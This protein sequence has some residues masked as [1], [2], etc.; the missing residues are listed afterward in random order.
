M[1]SKPY[2]LR[3]PYS[4]NVTNPVSGFAIYV[5]IGSMSTEENY[6]PVNLLLQLN[7]YGYQR[8]LMIMQIYTLK[9][10][11]HKPKVLFTQQTLQ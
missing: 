8:S 1:A 5:G 7:P 2:R 9:V 4:G 3:R 11:S 10:Q 6:S